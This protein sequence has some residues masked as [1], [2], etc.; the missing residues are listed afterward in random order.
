MPFAKT[1][2]FISPA[3]IYSR[4]KEELKAYFNTGSVDEEMFEVWTL[5][6][7]R[8]F[9]ATYLPIQDAAID[10]YNFKA[11]LPCDFKL[12]REVWACGVVTR[13]PVQSPFT[14]YYQTDCRINPTWE[15]C[16]CPQEQCTPWWETPRPV[17]LPNLCNL[18]LNP[19]N[20]CFCT[21][22]DQFRVTHKVQTSMNFSFTVE[23]ML[24]PGDYKTINSLWEHS[25]NRQCS[26]QNTFNIRDN[27]IVT[28]FRC[29]TI[30]L[31]Y[32]AEPSMTEDDYYE[33]PDEE[34]FQKYVYYYLRYMVYRTL[35]DQSTDE[36]FA[37]ISK[38][39]QLAEAEM[40]EHRMKAQ[41]EAMSQSVFQVRNSIVR[42]YNKNNKYKIR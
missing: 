19:T 38:K 9:K 6:C 41:Q 3:P 37:I 22:G 14:F 29:G 33:I 28:S 5:D 39:L 2:K 13:G 23:E 10:I 8:E 7:L 26:S 11:E 32:Y 35:L 27:K 42:S 17:N 18:N 25:P 16:A 12:V 21:S 24:I 20:G 40:L 34:R 15:G 31:L 1:T 36:T 4:I 30:Y